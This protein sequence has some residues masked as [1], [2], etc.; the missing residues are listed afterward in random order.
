MSEMEVKRIPVSKNRT[1]FTYDGRVFTL[2]GESLWWVEHASA[3]VALDWHPS[4]GEPEEAIRKF[5]PPSP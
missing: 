1:D 3:L 2:L 4:D 5:S